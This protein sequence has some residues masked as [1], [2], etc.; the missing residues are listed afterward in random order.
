MNGS[1]HRSEPREDASEPQDGRSSTEA[2]LGD[3]L[4]RALLAR[5]EA[6]RTDVEPV[7]P[8]PN[9]GDEW[10]VTGDDVG[11]A[12]DALARRVETGERRQSLALSGLDRTLL[13]LAERVEQ[14]EGQ[15]RRASA[16]VQ[17][18]VGD[19]RRAA[20]EITERLDNAET[21]AR[22]SAETATASI[23]TFQQRLDSARERLERRLEEIDEARR[24]ESAATF[25]RLSSA[26]KLLA[27]RLAAAERE[28]G[29]ARDAAIAKIEAERAAIEAR[30][31]SIVSD[32]R[33]ASEA[34]LRLLRSDTEALDARLTEAATVA[35]TAAEQALAGARKAFEQL[36]AKVHE[37]SRGQSSETAKVVEQIGAVQATLAERIA[38][39]ERLAREAAE[40]A[41]S[42]GRAAREAIETRLVTMER[43][44]EQTAENIRAGAASA[45]GQMR[46]AQLEL[47]A[48]VESVEKLARADDVRAA[49]EQRLAKLEKDGVKGLD[50]TALH[51]LDAKITALAA[52]VRDAKDRT[53]AEMDSLAQSRADQVDA[54]RIETIEKAL[55]HAVARLNER[56]THAEAKAHAAAEAAQAA[57]SGPAADA[58]HLLALI[59]ERL[60]SV[61]A[62]VGEMVVDVRTEVASQIAALAPGEDAAE[63][64]TAVADVNRRIASAE[65]RHAQ[66]IEAISLEIRR[67][68]EGV[69][70]RLRGLEARNDDASAEAVREEVARLSAALDGRIL[71]VQNRE[72]AG[73][74]RMGA[75]IGRLAERFDQRFEDV[76]RRSAE[77]IEHIG[78]QVA[79]VSER[80]TQ[81]QEQTALDIT[82]KLATAEERHGSR[83]D[84]ALGALSSKLADLE[85]RTQAALSP[86]QRALSTFA[87]RLEAVEDDETDYSPAAAPPPVEFGVAEHLDIEPPLAEQDPLDPIDDRALDEEEDPATPAWFAE[88]QTDA[89]PLDELAASA[90]DELPPERDNREVRHAADDTLDPEELFAE[91]ELPPA[92]SDYLAAA[93]RAAQAQANAG[94]KAKSE[95]RALLPLKGRLKL[96]GFGA[97]ALA[98]AIA[99]GSMMQRLSVDGDVNQTAEAEPVIPDRILAVAEPLELTPPSVEVTAALT[100]LADPTSSIGE[101]SAKAKQVQVAAAAPPAQAPLVAALPPSGSL[102]QAAARGDPVAQYELAL[103]RLSS[104]MPDEGV[105]LLRRAANQGLAMAQYRLGKLFER[106]E[107]VPPDL[108]QARQWTERAAAAGNRKAMHDLGVFY[109]R[110]EGVELDEATAFRWFRQAAEMGVADSQ[111]NLG[112]LYQQGRGVA[113]NPAEALYWF[114]VAAKAG[115]ADARAKVSSLQAQLGSQRGQEIVERAEAFVARPSSARAN[116]EFGQRA[117]GKI[118]AEGPSTPQS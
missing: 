30:M 11:S 9:D 93:R 5:E 1:A 86:L 79:R 14:T 35:Q 74:D 13:G 38:A 64:Q 3:W 111:Y 41:A 109:A 75:E 113:A 100:P 20:K 29:A 66:T 24:T 31:Q 73:F 6:A 37:A 2:A 7:Q 12:I 80:L 83:L 103:V 52:A 112:V 117:W 59:D 98:I 102:E 107:G 81:R 85:D 70:R 62:K 95:G 21:I 48:K 116:G 101:T 51:T 92:K 42:D 36:S 89:A 78:E 55:D 19:L 32:G 27:D 34:A 108:N 84:E 50:R 28:T 88:T 10:R 82:Q 76:E 104:G 114:T 33:K 63:L 43:A 90:P 72:A 26:Q 46:A 115:D 16:S 22:S 18:A 57:P 56:L 96:F 40:R 106:G 65:R 15:A 94:G 99:A 53:L 45:L 49:L 71:D 60:E 77:A 17:G 68:S 91:A 69:D 4:H 39:A 44:A 87:S 47:Q 105:L 8:T 54:G 118:A 58:D 23:E 97:G 25:E 61:T 67:M 110:G